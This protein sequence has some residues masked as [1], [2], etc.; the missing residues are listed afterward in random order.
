MTMFLPS[1]LT[2]DETAL[3]ATITRDLRVRRSPSTPTEE[4]AVRMEATQVAAEMIW[5]A[6]RE[7]TGGQDPEEEGLEEELATSPYHQRLAR[8]RAANLALQEAED[9]EADQPQ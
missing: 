7:L 2:A 3:V 4:E 1:D 8:T 9:E 6:R 5:E